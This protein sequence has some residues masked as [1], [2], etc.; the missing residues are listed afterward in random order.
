M[1]KRAALFHGQTVIT[2]TGHCRPIRVTTDA[3]GRCAIRLRAIAQLAVV[4]GSPGPKTAVLLQSDRV[5]GTTSHGLP[6]GLFANL[7]WRSLITDGFSTFQR[8][9][10]PSPQGPVLFYRHIRARR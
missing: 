5:A 8:P 1:P 2:T 6:I 9:P 3:D 4:V 7:D 10:A